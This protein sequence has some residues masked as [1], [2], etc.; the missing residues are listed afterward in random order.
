MK[1]S[2]LGRSDLLRMNYCS[3]CPFS[4]E[5]RFPGYND[6]AVH[7]R[8]RCSTYHKNLVN[9]VRGSYDKIHTLSRYSWGSV[10]LTRN[11]EFA[12]SLSL[13]VGIEQP[14]LCGIDRVGGGGCATHEELIAARTV[15]PQGISADELLRYQIFLTFSCDNVEKVHF[16]A[17]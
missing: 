7:V 1:G 9:F 6:R 3:R 16:R 12:T 4:L 14:L 5:Q 13:L 15:W 2:D 8:A 11:G 10:E 17:R